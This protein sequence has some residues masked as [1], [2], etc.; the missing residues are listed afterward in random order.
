[1]THPHRPRC[2]RRTAFTLIELLVV[3]SIIALLISLLLPALRTAR[4]AGRSTQCLSGLRQIGLA[5]VL[6]QNDHGDFFPAIETGTTTGVDLK[7]WPGRLWEAKYLSDP[8]VYVC[9]SADELSTRWLDEPRP[10]SALDTD[11]RN[12]HY[13]ANYQHIYG[14]GFSSIYP[15][16]A[17]GTR[18]PIQVTRIV[19]TAKTISMLD[20]QHG[21]SPTFSW[22]YINSYPIGG[23][24]HRPHARHM[25][26]TNV[27]VLW[28]D[29]HASPVIVTNPALPWDTGLT[30]WTLERQ[31]NWWDPY[32]TGS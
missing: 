8:R 24:P 11:W 22:F 19:D 5:V 1:M 3:I 10:T 27:N 25:N 6:Y 26:G 21:S 12:I 4:E 15:D 29:G 31:S 7:F 18:Y 28:A 16:R 17:A 32:P 23:S 14:N 20:A 13:A 9:P 2:P 30:N